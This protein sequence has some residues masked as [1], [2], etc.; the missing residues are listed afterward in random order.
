MTGA[1][2]LQR[3]LSLRDLVPFFFR[4]GLQEYIFERLARRQAAE[5]LLQHH[6]SGVDDHDAVADLRNLGQ[7]MGR[8]H[9]RACANVALTRIENELPVVRDRELLQPFG[10]PGEERVG[11][12]PRVRTAV[13][14]RISTRSSASA[15]KTE[16][17][18]RTRM[19]VCLRTVRAA[20]GPLRAT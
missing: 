19:G 16:P 7:D 14:E 10:L 11:L 4:D 13:D 1:N 12:L 18:S 3:L 9:D 17:V 5:A 6:A 15:R 20:T 2:L 8:E